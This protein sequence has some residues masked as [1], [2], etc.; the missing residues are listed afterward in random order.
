MIAQSWAWVTMVQDRAT[1]RGVSE[2]LESTFS[3]AE[4]CSLCEMIQEQRQ[5]QK[6]QVPVLETDP[7]GKYCPIARERAIKITPHIGNY[8]TRV[9]AHRFRAISRSDA[10]AIPPPRKEA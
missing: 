9:K 2:A 6:Q 10:P 7:L 5:E 1:E 8:V 3:G 4:P